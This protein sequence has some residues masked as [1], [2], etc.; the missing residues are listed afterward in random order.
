[1]R[2]ELATADG[3]F[4]RAQYIISTELSPNEN[5]RAYALFNLGVRLREAGIPTRAKRVFN[6]L[7]SMPVY[8]DDALDLKSACPHRAIRDRSATHSVGLS[9]GH[10][11]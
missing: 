8:T 5:L 10:V 3:D 1:M 2:A 9:G 7:A 6:Y 11:A 4:D